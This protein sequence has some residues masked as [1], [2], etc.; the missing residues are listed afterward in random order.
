MDNVFHVK[1]NEIIFFEN[2]NSQLSDEIIQT[3]NETKCD[4]IIFGNYFNQKV[5]QLPNS[6]LSLTFGNSFNQ[7]IDNLPQ[8]LTSLTFRNNFNQNVDLLP[9]SILS[10][11]FGYCFNQPVDNL[12]KKFDIQNL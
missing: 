10:L 7:S 5:D 1:N 4:T 6:I 2:F 9:N 12:P 3:I 8:K 11:T